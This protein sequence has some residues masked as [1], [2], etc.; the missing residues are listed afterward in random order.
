MLDL[1]EDTIKQK[2]EEL[3][4]Q[5]LAAR[6]TGIDPK[7]IKNYRLRGASLGKML[8]V[9]FQQDLLRFKDDWDE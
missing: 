5:P 8:E 1:T 6:K 4:K 7:A 3:V 9:L 2:F